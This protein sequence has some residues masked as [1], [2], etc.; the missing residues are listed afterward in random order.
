MLKFAVLGSGNGGR[1]FCAQIA[2]KGYPVT[3][4]EPLDEAPDFSRIAE[5]K[6]MFLEGDMTLG[7]PIGATKDIADAMKG[8]AVLL[9]VVPSFAHEPIFKKMIP[10]LEDGQH[11]LIVPGNFAAYRLKAMMDKFGCTKK[12]T[13]SC[14]ETMPYACRIKSFDVVNIFKKK[15]TVHIATSPSSAND[16]VLG[17]FNDVFDGY[18]HFEKFDHLLMIDMSNVNFTL[19]PLPVLLNY[20]D[21]E[22]PPKTFRHYMDGITPLISEQMHRMDAERVEAGKA[23]GFTLTPTLEML[24]TY[25]GM[26]ETKTIYEYVNS[27]ETPYADLVGHNVRGR[28]LT[29]DVPGVVAPVSRIAEK[30]GFRT[31]LSSLVVDL[32]SQLHGTDYWTCGTT[33]ESLGIGDKSIDE[34]LDMMR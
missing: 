29:E 14:T 19:H 25:Y 5:R 21:I 17:I 26:N 24:K 4:W 9:V 7:G 18:V 13:I 27:P 1:A 20:G 23:V 10:L 30:A 34:I 11:I 31:P 6:E 15:F 8:A 2:A 22:K 12:V 3:M 33:L 16:E 32:A 28:Y